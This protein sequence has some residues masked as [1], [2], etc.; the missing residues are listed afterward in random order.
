VDIRYGTGLDAIGDLVDAAV[1]AGV[2]EKRGAHYHFDGTALGQGR[3]RVREAMIADTSLFDRVR[4]QLAPMAGGAA[5]STR[6]SVDEG[7]AIP[8]AAA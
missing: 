2:I 7:T 5:E 1:T 3:E 8:A 4:A 6:A